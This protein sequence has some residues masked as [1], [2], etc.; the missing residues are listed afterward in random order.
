[1]PRRKQTLPREVREQYQWYG[2]TT[3]VQKTLV[4]KYKWLRDVVAQFVQQ[5]PSKK[6]GDGPQPKKK[7]AKLR[8]WRPGTLALKEIRKY[9]KSTN[10]VIS[11][12]AMERTIRELCDEYVKDIRWSNAAVMAIHHA[13][14]NYCTKLFEDVNICAIHAKRETIMP[15]DIQLA[16]R[17]RG[18]RA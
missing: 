5:N 1:M 14:E 3:W 9:Q 11:K 2:M 8:R 4:K 12:A 7:Q 16:R 6:T 18:E 17:I 15:K 13:T 10:L